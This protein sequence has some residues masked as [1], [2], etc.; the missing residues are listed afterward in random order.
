MR[1]TLVKDV[2]LHGPIFNSWSDRLLLVV[3]S[4]RSR[5]ENKQYQRI[6]EEEEIHSIMMHLGSS[7]SPM[8]ILT[9]FV[10]V[11]AKCS[12]VEL[13]AVLCK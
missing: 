4:R 9:M 6:E 10:R 3:R 2:G 11:P 7:N 13:D 1:T 12:S 5:K 8:S